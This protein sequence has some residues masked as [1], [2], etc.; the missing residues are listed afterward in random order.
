MESALMWHLYIR[1]CC[2]R[3]AE[4]VKREGTYMKWSYHLAGFLQDTLMTRETAERKPIETTFI[5]RGNPQLLSQKK[6][7]VF[8]SNATPDLNYL[9]ITGVFNALKTLPIA[10]AGGWHS[11]MEKVLFTTIEKS[12]QAN[13][14]YYLARDLNSYPFNYQQQEMMRAGKLLVIGRESS[15]RRINRHS[16]RWRNKLIFEQTDGVLFL[17]IRPEGLLHGCFEKLILHGEQVFV[18]DIP[19]NHRFLCSDA[20]PVNRENLTDTILL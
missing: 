4:S 10:L 13:Y 19:E 14:V 20:I 7:A 2:Y 3:S 5:T 6:L 16:S 15:Q 12:D 9:E 8:A 1:T 11:F 17:Y 18:L